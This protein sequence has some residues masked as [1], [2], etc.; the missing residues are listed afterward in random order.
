MAALEVQHADLVL[1]ALQAWM[2][3]FW[4]LLAGY[5]DCLFGHFLAT[6]SLV[7]LSLQELILDPAV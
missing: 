4:F 5:L 7:H 6:A 1:T 3:Q 2:G